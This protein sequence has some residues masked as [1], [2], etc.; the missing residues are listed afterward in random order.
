MTLGITGASGNLGR[1]TTEALLERVDPG[2][3]VLVTRTP[4]KLSEVAARG[5]EVRH[6]DFSDTSTL[7]PAFAG[8]DRL[9][10]ISTDVIRERM[11]GHL[12]AID[13][14]RR[15]GVSH[16]LYTSGIKPVP[17]NPAVAAADHGA[18]EE[19]LRDSGLEWSFLRN[20]LYTEHQVP[21]ASQAIA[22]GRHVHNSGDGG[23][24][25]VSRADCAAAAAGALVGAAQPGWAYDITGPEAVTEAD[26]AALASELS[27]R[28]IEVVE[29]DDDAYVAGLV[30]HAGLPEQVARNLASF[31]A[32]A[33]EGFA[34]TVADGV[35]E[36]S[37]RAPRSL[38]EVLT[39][40]LDELVPA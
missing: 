4:S 11:P 24:S 7:D 14:A 27:G 32:S 33:R 3:L 26:L 31:G 6:G 36:L 8:I 30:E 25:H 19:A 21:T 38:R 10:L 39:T 40:H 35:Q 20:S 1:L 28:P 17:E 13:A 16:V 15:A 29:L 37:G 22:S 12:A 18:T 23:V 2:D 34:D 9:L 5:A